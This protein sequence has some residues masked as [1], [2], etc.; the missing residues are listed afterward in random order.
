MR[1]DQLVEGLLDLLV[2][3]RQ[4]GDRFLG[5]LLKTH[6]IGII[7]EGG[8]NALGNGLADSAPIETLARALHQTPNCL[9][10][11]ADERSA[12]ADAK[13]R[14]EGTAIRAE[15]IKNSLNKARS[16]N[17]P[18]D[19]PG[20]VFVKV[21]QNWLE[22]EHVRKGIYTAMEEFLRK[23]ER[24]V[25][26]V[27][28]T[29]VTMELPDKKMMLLRHRFHEFLNPSHRFDRTKNWALFKDYKVPEE[30][31]GAHPKGVRVFSQGFVMRE[32]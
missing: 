26:V 2:A 10:K 19:E 14:L 15:T 7:L 9:I 22:Q 17:L 8:D 25:S 1:V 18:P 30:W 24:I 11:Y 13:C 3:C 31:G 20:I 16:N 27:V 28:Y 4:L 5:L 12:C 23:T 32:R 6:K 29:T 21:P